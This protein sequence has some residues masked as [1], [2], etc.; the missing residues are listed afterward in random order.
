MG[1]FLVLLALVLAL[2]LPRL[3][4]AR[5]GFRGVS[6]QLHFSEDEVSEGDT[7]YLTETVVN[8]KLLPLPWLKAE[9]TTHAAL[10]FAAAQSAVSEE[11]RF[12]SSHFS[13][14][15]YQRIERRWKVKCTRRGI[16]TVSRAVIVLTD[17]FGT[18]E[19]SEP[20]PEAF[21]EITV[22][23]AVHPV[24]ALPIPADAVSGEYIRSRMLI[25]DRFAVCGIRHYLPGDA[26][27]DISQTASARTEQPMVWQYQETVTP[28][29]SIVLL[30]N[31][32]PRDRDAVSD[33]ARF[34]DAVRVCAAYAWL[35]GQM[36]I[37]VRFCTNAEIGG[38]AVCGQFSA[39]DAAVLSILRTLSALPYDIA[40]KPETLVQQVCAD[41]ASAVLI[42]GGYIAPEI[43][44][45][46]QHND[47]IMLLPVGNQAS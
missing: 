33:K 10:D 27:R 37:S 4:L 8:R 20:M 29:L 32:R 1:L 36:K 16:F 11:T 14:M 47:R 43:A 25:P 42:I 17:L 6:Y 28:A 40:G 30:M 5:Y 13:L 24:D 41:D 9:L 31:T 22:L 46:A 7:V 39:G 18:S 23:P 35:A 19:L 34:E 3:L 26:L 44:A 21:A 15:P 12:V 2:T 45:Y 38:N